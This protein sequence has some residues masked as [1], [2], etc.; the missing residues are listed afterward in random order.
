MNAITVLSFFAFILFACHPA[1]S[2]EACPE[3]ADPVYCKIAKETGGKVIFVD[4]KDDMTESVKQLLSDQSL[5]KEEPEKRSIFSK[6][7]GCDKYSEGRAKE[8]CVSIS[9]NL[10]WGWTGHAMFAPGWR[11]GT[12]TIKNVFCEKHITK[13]DLKVLTALCGNDV[14]P[15]LA[16]LKPENARLSVSLEGLINILRGQNKQLPEDLAGTIYNPESPDYILEKG[17]DKK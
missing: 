6:D 7:I 15:Y 9:E 14:K 10:E 4:P 2:D 16:C 3:R 11:S 5:K 12:E 17:C 1:Y 13:D 8:I